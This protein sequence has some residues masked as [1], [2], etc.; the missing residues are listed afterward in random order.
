MS[1]TLPPL[2]DV[3]ILVH[4]VA[5]TEPTLAE[6]SARSILE[7]HFDDV[8]KARMDD[9]AVKNQSGSLTDVERGELERFQRVGHLLNL[10]QAKARLSLANRANR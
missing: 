5:P 2:T 8:A 4:V 3:D 9:L 6:A 7:L 10:L 1:S